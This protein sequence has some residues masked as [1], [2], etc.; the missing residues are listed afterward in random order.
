MEENHDSIIRAGSFKSFVTGLAKK[1]LIIAFI[2]GL[3]IFAAYKYGFFGIWNYKVTVN[4][5]TP[6]GIRQG[7]AVRSVRVLRTFTLLGTSPVDK[8]PIGEAVAIDLGK[9]GYLF[10]TTGFDDYTILFEAFPPPNK[11]GLSFEGIRYYN[12]IGN[13]KA[14]L[15][16]QKYPFLVAFKDIK[17]PLSVFRVTQENS[18]QV[19]GQGVRIR[20]V[21]V[22]MTKEP[23]TKRIMTILPWLSNM[24]STSLSGKR[25]T[26]GKALAD[27]LS[28]AYFIQGEKYGR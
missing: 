14:S 10:A 15:D 22:E 28:G 19:I 16:L 6:E 1:L 20:S 5:E 4:V 2:I 9:Q 25:Y 23:V 26:G 13:V 7:S 11:A 27:N 18:E 3:L 8:N 24:W 17:N 12:K 21:T